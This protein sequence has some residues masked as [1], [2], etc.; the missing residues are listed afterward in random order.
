MGRDMRT[1]GR[2]HVIGTFSCSRAM[3]FCFW[4]LVQEIVA[5][6]NEI[7]GIRV[8]KSESLRLGSQSEIKDRG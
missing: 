1:Q 4:D 5:D 6:V 3:G 2:K 8:E 7:A